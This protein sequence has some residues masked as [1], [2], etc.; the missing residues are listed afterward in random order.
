MQELNAVVGVRVLPAY[1]DAVVANSP[2]AR[3]GFMPG[4]KIVAIITGDEVAYDLS[5]S[6]GP[7]LK[8]LWQEYE[9]VLGETRNV[10]RCERENRPALEPSAGVAHDVTPVSR[11]F[12]PPTI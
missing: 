11:Q 1:V 12:G 7:R 9:E 5:Q 2:A 10:L 6:R 8:S 3:A 4:D